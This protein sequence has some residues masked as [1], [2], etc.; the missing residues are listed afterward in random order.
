VDGASDPVGAHQEVRRQQRLLLLLLRWPIRIEGRGGDQDSRLQPG[1]QPRQV[2][3][4]RLQ[5][6]LLV[7]QMP[8][9]I[10]HLQ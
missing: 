9:G 6:L 1:Q 8:Q 2:A 7:R 5:H 10:D 3:R 4:G